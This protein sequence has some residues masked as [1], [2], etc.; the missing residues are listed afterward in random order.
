[1]QK[2]TAGGTDNGAETPVLAVDSPD[3]RLELGKLVMRYEKAVAQRAEANEELSAIRQAVKALGRR[4]KAFEM[5]IRLKA[6]DPAAREEYDES[7]RWCRKVM[8]VADQVLMD[9]EPQGGP[10]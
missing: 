7:L 3:T 1:M 8:G 2:Q 4:P 5:A 9:L 6:M 10:H